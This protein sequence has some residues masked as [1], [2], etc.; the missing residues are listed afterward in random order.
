MGLVSRPATV[1]WYLCANISAWYGI[2]PA[3]RPGMTPQ[4]SFYGKK[5]TFEPTV[6][7][8]RFNGVLGAAWVI[9][10]VAGHHGTDSILVET[11]GE[12]QQF[13]H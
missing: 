10:A 12:E 4:K 2:I 7:R 5:K 1:I 9:A 8:N 6:M 3:F 11:D 13:A